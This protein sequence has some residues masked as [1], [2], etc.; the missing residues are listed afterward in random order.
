M[1]RL[2]FQDE[3]SGAQSALELVGYAKHA[4]GLDNVATVLADLS[5]TMDAE[6]LTEQAAKSPLAWCQRLGYLLELV[7]AVEAASLL[8]PYVDQRAKRVAPLDPS[9]PRTGSRR[10]ERWRIAINTD[11]E[12]DS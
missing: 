3:R 1:R 2:Y 9:R 4:G 7:R 8:L 5:E 11:V 12:V 6:L 10:S